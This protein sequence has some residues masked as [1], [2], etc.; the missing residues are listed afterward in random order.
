MAAHH[1][2]LTYLSSS[3][4]YLARSCDHEHRAGRELLRRVGTEAGCEVQLL[5]GLELVSGRRFTLDG[6]DLEPRLLE[7]LQIIRCPHPVLVM[8]RRVDEAPS[9]IG[10]AQEV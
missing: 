1:T 9:A 5:H 3:D 10:E 6:Q 7:E 8:E 2:S 4:A